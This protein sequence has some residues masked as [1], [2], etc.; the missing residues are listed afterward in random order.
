[1]IQDILFWLLICS[2]GVTCYYGYLL[3]TCDEIQAMEPTGKDAR[4]F[5][6]GVWEKFLFLD[7]ILGK[8]KLVLPE[9]KR[10]LFKYRLA[11]LSVLIFAIPLL[12]QMR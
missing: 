12:I 8:K 6:Y 9:T 11:N 1:M 3:R 5:F 4:P 10:L 7:L 2:L